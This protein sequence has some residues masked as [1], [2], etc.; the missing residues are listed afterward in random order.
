MPSVSSHSCRCRAGP[1]WRIGGE[2]QFVGSLS[3]YAAAGVWTEGSE[4][5]GRE[6]PPLG[7]LVSGRTPMVLRGRGRDRDR[8]KRVREPTGWSVVALGLWDKTVSNGHTRGQRQERGDGEE[9][10]VVEFVVETGKKSKQDAI[11]ISIASTAE[12]WKLTWIVSRWHKKSP[13]LEAR[14]G[15]PPKK[16]R[17][18]AMICIRGSMMY[19]RRPP[20]PAGPSTLERKPNAAK[21]GRPRSTKRWGGQH[22]SQSQRPEPGDSPQFSGQTARCHDPSTH[23]PHPTSKQQPFISLS[24][25]GFHGHLTRLCSTRARVHP[26]GMGRSSG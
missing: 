13:M 10:G 5:Q 9:F 2:W 1:S 25:P 16:A 26:A 11:K 8:G 14:T 12:A 7:L 21:A 19:S 24:T 15:P 22:P 17:C 4:R 23:I 6:G 18:A 20:F 3:E